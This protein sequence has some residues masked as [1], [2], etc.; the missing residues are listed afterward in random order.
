[1]SK[2][3]TIENIYKLLPRFVSESDVK[4]TDKCHLPEVK[5]DFERNGVRFNFV[6]SPALIYNPNEGNKHYYPGER[7]KIVELA[8]REL[9]VEENPNF[10]KSNLALIFRLRYFLEYLAHHSAGSVY[11]TG[12]IELSLHILSGTTYQLDDGKSE[13]YVRPVEELKRV[14]ENEEVYYYLQFSSMFLGDNQVFDYCF[15]DK[16]SNKPEQDEN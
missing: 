13:M 16:N 7:E 9:A 14:E 2:P 3:R 8:L 12:E 11:T 15:G 4:H 10:I 5:R 1:M 6:I